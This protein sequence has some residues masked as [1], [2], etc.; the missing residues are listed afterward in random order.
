M[1][2]SSTSEEKN[3]NSSGVANQPIASAPVD[4]TIAP[5]KTISN[6][7]RAVNNANP[8][9]RPL[10][11]KKETS[12]DQL[13]SQ[14]ETAVLKE[15]VENLKAAIIAARREVEL[16]PNS[17]EALMRLGKTLVVINNNEDVNLIVDEIFSKIL[18]LDPDNLAAKRYLADARYRSGLYNSALI[19]LEPLL[20]DGLL[21]DPKTWGLVNLCFLRDEQFENGLDFFKRMAEKHPGDPYI[22]LNRAVLARHVGNFSLARAELKKVVARQDIPDS[23]RDTAEELLTICQGGN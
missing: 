20:E 11:V 4:L 16:H 2:S 18:R 3:L 17:V 22:L 8:S 6:D 12:P 5:R 13:I 10:V 1:S 14:A 9:N 7:A 19:I 15:D 23:L 21:S